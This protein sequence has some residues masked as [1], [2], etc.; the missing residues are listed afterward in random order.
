[1]NAA[2]LLLSHS[3]QQTGLQKGKT[4]SWPGGPPGRRNK[5]KVGCYS[6]K[7]DKAFF[8]IVFLCTILSDLKFETV[9]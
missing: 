7:N 9:L 6:F 2:F 3:P 8:S 5:I 4:G 1:M